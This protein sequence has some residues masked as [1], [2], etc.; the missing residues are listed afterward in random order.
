[1]AFYVFFS[2]VYVEIQLKSRHD[3]GCLFLLCRL[4]HRRKFIT[5]ILTSPDCP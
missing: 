2:F 3:A 1:M 5:A 4:L